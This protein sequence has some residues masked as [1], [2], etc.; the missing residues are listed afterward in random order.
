MR[1]ISIDTNRLL[2][3]C[4]PDPRPK[5]VGMETGQIKADK[6]GN[7]VFTV[8]RSA[9]DRLTGPAELMN[10]SIST[11]PGVTIGQ[12]VTPVGLTA[13][14]WEQTRNG[15]SRSGV[16]FRADSIVQATTA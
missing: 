3:V 14:P 15:Q 1:N 7:T 13:I 8:G 9:A 10:V 6:A 5:L 16:A 4:I 2:F 11:D 12:I